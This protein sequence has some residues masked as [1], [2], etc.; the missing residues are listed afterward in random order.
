M[1]MFNYQKLSYLLFII[2]TTITMNNEPVMLEEVWSSCYCYSC[3]CSLYYFIFIFIVAYFIFIWKSEGKIYKNKTL[4]LL[5]LMLMITSQQLALLQCI[6]YNHQ[7]QCI[8]L[9]EFAGLWANKDFL[10]D[11]LVGWLVASLV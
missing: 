10:V 6:Y 4:L 7:I 3:C 11:L 2:S 1:F 9:F 5:L 8:Q